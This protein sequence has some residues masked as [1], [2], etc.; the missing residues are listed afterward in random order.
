LQRF[1]RPPGF[2]A[3]DVADA[4]FAWLPRGMWP[5]VRVTPLA[6][7][8]CAFWFAGWPGPLLELS[9]DAASSDE[10]RAVYRITGGALCAVAARGRGLLEFRS[11][12]GGEHVMA[13]VS[14]FEPRLPWLVYKFSQ[15]LVHLAVMGAFGRHL[16]R[17]GR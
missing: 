6:E 13:L 2:S 8:G 7:P 12:L 3:R 10:D 11:V 9:Y 5:F 1:P 16:A 14:G 4:Y 15:A 17:L